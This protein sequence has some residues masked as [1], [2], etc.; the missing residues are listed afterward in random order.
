MYIK[1]LP[2]NPRCPFGAIQLSGG[3]PKLFCFQSLLRLPKISLKF[4]YNLA[5]II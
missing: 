4:T 1:Q 3:V 2:T 5:K